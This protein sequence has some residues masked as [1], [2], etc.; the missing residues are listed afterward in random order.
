[1]SH[2]IESMFYHKERPWHG[3]GVELDHPATSEEAIKAASLDWEVELEPVY[4]GSLDQVVTVPNAQAVVRTDR[5][6][7]LGIVG[8]RYSPM[9]NRDAFT[10]FDR[11]I[12]EGKAVYET[13]GSLERGRRIWLLARLPEDVWVTDQD[14]VRKYLLLT[15][16]HDG[17]SPMRAMFTPIR[18]VC[19]NTLSAAL[20]NGKGT[21]VSIRH[22]GDMMDKASEAQRILGISMKYYDT[23]SDQAH[24]F[25]RKSLTRQALALY[26][27]ELVPDPEKAD[28]NRA[29]K[30]RKELTRL[31][32]K[33]KGNSLPSVRGSLW[34]AVN[35]VA[36]YV[37][38]DRP[39]RLAKGDEA[40]T[41]RFQSAIFGSGAILKERAWDLA[42][43]MVS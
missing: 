20:G 6:E 32:T 17:R 35:S 25:V 16:S 8:D 43:K 38:H 21:G 11:L 24:T 12:G 30:T 13:A 9:Q 7:P 33:G 28:P 15:T 4:I 27:E 23:W 1:M 41:K 18:V 5:R 22:T 36:E 31:F 42:L 37:D 40:K 3:L 10:F 2:R 14:N 34:A 29:R 39:T 26:Y 19:H